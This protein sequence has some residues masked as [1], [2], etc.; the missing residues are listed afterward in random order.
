MR[1]NFKIT[2]L[3]YQNNGY[4]FRKFLNIVRKNSGQDIPDLMVIMMN[5]GS[6]KPLD[7]NENNSCETE[8]IPDN[9]QD[10]IMRVMNR[11][12]FDFARILNLSDL[13]EPKSSVFYKKIEELKRQKITH[14][15]FDK[16]RNSDYEKFFVKNVPVIFAWGVSKNLFGLAKIATETI[17]AI[18]PIGMNK[19]GFEFGYYHPLPQNYNKQIEWVDEISKM[20][21]K[22]HNN[23]YNS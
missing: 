21:K 12:N 6:S 19:K 8:A 11:C 22:A 10:Q 4:Y 16:E 1:S 2:G 17:G 14:S 23:V 5:P 9:T 7:G 3:F 18:E 13:R 15:I 20:I